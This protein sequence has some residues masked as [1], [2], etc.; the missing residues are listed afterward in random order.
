MNGKSLLMLF[1][2]VGLGLGAMFATQLYLRKPAAA[3]DETQEILV[4]ARDI[5]D[6][7]ILKPDAVKMVRMSK[8]AI[9]VGTFSSFKEVEDR[10]VK[11]ALLEGDPVVEKRLG[12]KGTPPGLVA[13]IPKGMRAF[14]VEVNEQSGVSGFILPGHHV[15]VVRFDSNERTPN[16]R[17]ETILQN[18]QVLAAGQVFTRAEEKSVQS[19]TVTLAVT[20]EQVDALVAAKA[21]GPLSLSLRGVNDHE[22]VQRALPKPEP[23]DETKNQLARLRKDLAAQQSQLAA[24]KEAYSKLEKDHASLAQAHARKLAEPPPPP[25]APPKPPE[26]RWVHIYRPLHSR[27]DEDRKRGEYPERIAINEEARKLVDRER[28]ARSEEPRALGFGA[29]AVTGV[30]HE[31]DAESESRP[32][33]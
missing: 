28:Q 23:D 16:A 11:T 14:A 8:K 10:W 13:N 9:P 12:P 19:R 2:A 7:E 17:A 15:D 27:R 3:Q 24:H 6:E 31:L 33:E 29:T 30:N 22:V 18:V 5:K 1:M 21:K 25:P 32:D 20:P 26:K 4:A